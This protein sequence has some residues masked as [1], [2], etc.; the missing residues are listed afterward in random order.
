MDHEHP[1]EIIDGSYSHRL[2]GWKLEWTFHNSFHLLESISWQKF[3]FTLCVY[4]CILK[5]LFFFILSQLSDEP[6]PGATAL[7]GLLGKGRWCMYSIWGAVWASHIFLLYAGVA[8]HGYQV[9][10][11]VI[12]FPNAGFRFNSLLF[13]FDTEKITRKIGQSSVVCGRKKHPRQ[14]VF[15]LPAT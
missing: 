3:T 7:P 13:F 12:T 6:F 10:P 9:I 14:L 2:Q 8:S 5:P 15:P 1:V 4:P 11:E